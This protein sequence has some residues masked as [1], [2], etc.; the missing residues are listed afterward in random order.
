MANLYYFIKIIYGLLMLLIIL[1]R[2]INIITKYLNLTLT[3]VNI[4]SFYYHIICDIKITI[5]KKLT[6]IFL[7][8]KSR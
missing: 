8:H 6:N 2:Q 5:I 7:S 3:K 4:Y 1:Y